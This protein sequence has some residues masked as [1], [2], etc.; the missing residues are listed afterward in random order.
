MQPGILIFN[1]GDPDY[2]W[3]GNEAGIAPMPIWNTV[4]AVDFSVL[5]G[6]KEKLGKKLWLPAECDLMMR[7]FKW[8]YSD[9]DC[10]TVKSVDE[11]VGIYCYSV[12]RGCNMLLNIGPD[13]RGLFPKKD[14]ENLIK[15]GTEIRRSF[16]EPVLSFKDFRCKGDTW[17]YDAGNGKS[18]F[19]DTVI[20]QEDL[21]RGETVRRFRISIMPYTTGKHIT[22][23]EGY[24]IGHKAICQFPLIRAKEVLIQILESDGKAC[25]RD[26]RVFKRN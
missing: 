6:K 17:S 3:V 10:H 11:L 4:D 24:N 1:M 25:M 12:G 21:R 23:Y 8:F 19:M 18:F 16:S 22:V 20:L 5:T 13:R 15:F 26:I 7:D 14:K 2:R 9:E